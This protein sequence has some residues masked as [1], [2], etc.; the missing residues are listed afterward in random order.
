MAQA[1]ALAAAGISFSAPQLGNPAMNQ[2]HAL[3]AQGISAGP[4]VGMPTLAEEGGEEEVL[5][6]GP[7]S[8]RFVFIRAH[9]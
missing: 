6:G 5:P 7:G 9:R 2:I 8:A 4:V 1:H 3:I